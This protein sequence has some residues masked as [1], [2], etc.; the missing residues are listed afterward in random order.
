MPNILLEEARLHVKAEPFEIAKKRL[1]FVAKWTS[2][3]KALMVE[4][5]Q[6]KSLMDPIVA[7]VVKDKKIL[8]FEEMLREVDFPD[9]GLLMS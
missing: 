4:E 2:G 9:M 1:K 7:K 8:L 5:Q 3:A 6:L